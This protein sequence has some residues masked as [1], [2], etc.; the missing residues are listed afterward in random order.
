MVDKV[1]ESFKRD[2]L[3]IKSK[4]FVPSSRKH[5]TGIGKTFEDLIGIHENNNA[6]ADYKDLIE[7]KS[8]RELSESMITLF[9][10]SPSFPKGINAVL[11]EKYGQPDKTG[12]KI[13][14]TTI[15]AVK[16]NT[17]AE[18]FGFK[19]DVDDA[20]NKMFLKLEFSN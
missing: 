7:L 18:K 9:T 19:L 8:A 6:L 13:L 5:D 20:K 1:I 14:H 15:S 17:F 16:F 12:M 4:G 10:K 2:F 3:A 11:R